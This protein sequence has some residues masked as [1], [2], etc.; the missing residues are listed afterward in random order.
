[1]FKSMS[2]KNISNPKPASSVNSPPKK[3]DFK[4]TD[5]DRPSKK[6][7]D[8]CLFG[9]NL[10]TRNQ[11]QKPSLPVENWKQSDIYQSSTFEI[12]G[13]TANQFGD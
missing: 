12:D 11:N 1:M 6:N 4:N 3:Y 10:K 9:R 5:L 8:T 2:K 13:I 7:Q